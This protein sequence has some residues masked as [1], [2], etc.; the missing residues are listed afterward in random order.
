MG[1]LRVAGKPTDLLKRLWAKVI[2]GDPDTCWRWIGA[3]SR[4]GQRRVYYPVISQGLGKTGHSRIWRVGRL[5]L[6]L[7]Y[8]PKD[9]PKEAGEDFR[10]WLGRA[11]KFY[12]DQDLEA[13][14]QCD[15]SE[16]VNPG[17]LAWETHLENVSRQKVRQAKK[18]RRAA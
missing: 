1:I 2:I 14:H 5:L 9:V 15:N 13:G 12:R 3:K 7:E 8:G 18:V 16:C 6:V 10:T 11:N 17:H 4:S